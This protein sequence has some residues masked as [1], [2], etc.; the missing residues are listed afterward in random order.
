MY[1]ILD[2]ETTGGNAFTDK[3]TEIAIYLH[4]G[5]RVI[6]SFSSLVNPERSIPVF[7]SRLTGI[8]DEMVSTAPR[9]HEIAKQIVDITDGKIIVAHNA[10]N[11]YSFI[12]AEFRNLGY[13]YSRDSICTHI[14]SRKI[15]P[16]QTSYSLGKLCKSLNID[17]KSRHRACDDA[18][19]TVKLFEMILKNGEISVINQH[20]KPQ[21]E[22]VKL[23]ECI[24][25]EVMSLLPTQPGIF[26]LY[27]KSG[28]LLFV[29]KA[30]N[31][32]KGVIDFVI[33]TKGNKG[34]RIRHELHEIKHE[35]CGND[36][37]AAIRE[38]EEIKLLKPMYNRIHPRQVKIKILPGINS[39]LLICN[40]RHEAERGLVLIERG[41]L[42][43]YGFNNMDSQTQWKECIKPVTNGSHFHSLISRVI[44]HRRFEKIISLK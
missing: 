12:R 15:I 42:T 39:A 6:D 23:P 36:I 20:I 37:I 17:I 35:P 24:K 18:M 8:T 34:K 29:H 22:E 7:V 32:R 3:I 1:A 40:G 30:Y 16:G 43:G 11:D 28:H 13:D 26:Y 4:N 9:F 10:P 41:R 44:K 2:I 5:E 21:Q 25:P 19:A 33:K 14:L 27:N 31:L 38:E